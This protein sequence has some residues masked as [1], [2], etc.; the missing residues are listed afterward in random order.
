[1]KLSATRPTLFLAPEVD[2]RIRHWA[3]IASGEMSCLGMADAVD[4]GFL[5]AK[6]FLLHQTCGQ[7][8]T[9]MDQAAVARLLAELDASG[10]DVSR[11]RFWQHSHGSIQTFFSSQDEATIRSLSNQDWTLS[12]VVNKAGSQQARLDIWHPSVHVTIDELPIAVFHEDLGLREECEREFQAKVREAPPLP[13]VATGP[14]AG[15][16]EGRLDRDSIQSR[17]PELAWEDIDELLDPL[18]TGDGRFDGGP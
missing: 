13:V 3:A 17:F 14:H 1:M 10:E 12:L 11:L 4:G 2:Q 6:V 5:V 15:L 8:E 18:G 16:L 9:E 7:A